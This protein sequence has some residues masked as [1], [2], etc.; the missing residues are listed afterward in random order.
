LGLLER[1]TV[2]KMMRVS[3]KMRS[4]ERKDKKDRATSLY[5]I[6]AI[7]CESYQTYP[8]SIDTRMTSHPTAN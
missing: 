5:L 8:Y 6:F 3:A 2:R 4:K 7:H 1:R